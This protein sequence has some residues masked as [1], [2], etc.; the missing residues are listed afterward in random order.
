MIGFRVNC[1]RREAKRR[2][3]NH[4]GSSAR[5]RQTLR[6]RRFVRSF[7]VALRA[8]G[9]EADHLP[10]TRLLTMCRLVARRTGRYP[11]NAEDAENEDKC[12]RGLEENL[13]VICCGR[14]EVG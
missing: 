8:R 4:S 3:K 10:P 13:P 6:S 5:R 2:K 9:W 1:M 7:A 11:V 14:R 12:T